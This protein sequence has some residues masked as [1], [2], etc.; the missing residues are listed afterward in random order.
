[1]HTRLALAYFGD[2]PYVFVHGQWLPWFE[3]QAFDEGTMKERRLKLYVLERRWLITLLNMVGNW[4]DFFLLY[5]ANG[6]PE[7]AQVENVTY[8]YS[9]DGL[10]I[11]V[12]HESFPVVAAGS[13][14]PFADHVLDL[15]VV[16]M[17]KQ[18]DGSY[19]IPDPESKVREWF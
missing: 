19:R 3:Y 11:A 7:G 4:P 15:E 14:I 8:D 16:C 5:K 6:V 18:R 9:R 10:V 13:A 12:A 1:M 17:A 2:G